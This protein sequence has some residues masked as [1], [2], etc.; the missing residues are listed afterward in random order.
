MQL[1]PERKSE[2]SA[3]VNPE[4][5]LAPTLETFRKAHLR[6]KCRQVYFQ[7]SFCMSLVVFSHTL[8]FCL[9]Q[10]CVKILQVSHLHHFSPFLIFSYLLAN[11]KYFCLSLPVTDFV[12][13]EVDATSFVQ[14]PFNI[15]S[16][17]AMK[18]LK[19]NFPKHNLS[20]FSVSQP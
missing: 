6:K 17:K 8:Q 20:I 4:L 13:L 1:L 16:I 15:I 12:C 19:V 7:N 14:A 11:L 3:K 10:R 18:S 5:G 9:A 2:T